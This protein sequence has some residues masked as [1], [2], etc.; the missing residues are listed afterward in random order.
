MIET[1]SDFLSIAFLVICILVGVY[2]L[3]I[4]SVERHEQILKKMESSYYRYYDSFMDEEED[5]STEPYY[6]D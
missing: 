6:G 4:V 3:Y 5:D 2:F 1:V